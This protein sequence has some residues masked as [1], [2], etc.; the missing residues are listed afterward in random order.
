MHPTSTLS[1]PLSDAEPDASSPHGQ[2]REAVAAR[3][4]IALASLFL[5]IWTG[6]FPYS[7]DAD[8][9][10]H[11]LNARD[12]LAAPVDLLG[13]WARPLFKAYLLLP[14]QVGMLACRVAMTVLFAL[15]MQQT[16]ALARELRLP[17]PW[18]AGLFL[19]L[20]PT[21][22]GLAT[23]T[24]SEIPFA[25]GAVVA[26]RLWRRNSDTGAAKAGAIPLR[27]ILAT[28]LVSLLPMV[29]PEGFWLAAMWGVLILMDR[30]LSVWQ[31]LT[32]PSLLATGLGLWVLACWVIHGDPIYFIHVWSWPPESYETYGRGSLL[33]H[34]YRWPVFCGPVLCALFIAGI[35]PS[36][37]REMA[38]PWAVWGLVFVLHSVL[39]WRGW[40]ASIGLMR[41][42][43][44]T[45]PFTAIICLYGWNAIAGWLSRRGWTVTARRRLAGAT[46]LI[47]AVIP[48]LHYVLN[49]QHLRMFPS[50]SCAQY[51]HAHNLLDTAPAV[52]VADKLSLAQLHLP[53]KPAVF[54][55]NSYDK[56]E[57]RRMIAS[58]PIGTIGI[59]DNQRGTMW[60]ELTFDDLRALGYDTLHEATLTA[61][62]GRKPI[63]DWGPSD[64]L[65]T[66]RYV[67]V[68]KV[69]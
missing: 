54:S 27:L 66:Q 19:P 26:V 33:H 18:L 45:A 36:L 41:I 62:I 57:Q 22:F 69:R 23:D 28:L 21:V 16:M 39:Y 24:M 7:G 3:L 30:R 65:E 35:K 61:T 5:L 32:L 6:I 15:L 25:L 34:V 13:P 10:F 68:K 31:R 46:L 64:L 40:F 67:V 37:R 63:G 58:R 42:L 48:L 52:I 49:A 29:R 55:E 59:W 11:Y 53:P 17:R 60:Y 51:I 14:A 38:L 4:T 1:P 47:A 9:T 50:G 43:A 8:A 44:S 20:M 56:D 12:G 2:L